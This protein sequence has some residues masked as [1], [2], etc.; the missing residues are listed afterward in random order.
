MRGLLYIGCVYAGS[1]AGLA[2]RLLVGLVAGST[3]GVEGV[4][5]CAGPLRAVLA[6]PMV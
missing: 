2:V 4:A 1:T 6:V 5:D 3:A